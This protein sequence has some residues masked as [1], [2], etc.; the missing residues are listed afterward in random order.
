MSIDTRFDDL[1]F[2]RNI[3]ERSFYRTDSDRMDPIRFMP[4][5]PVG[6]EERHWWLPVAPITATMCGQQCRKRLSERLS[7]RATIGKFLLRDSLGTSH[8]HHAK[9]A[10]W[11]PSLDAPSY[12]LL[13]PE[14]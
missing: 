10:D 1:V 7:E 8:R 4:C 12:P 6:D 2:F 13:W 3:E 5:W 11:M 9:Q 14:L